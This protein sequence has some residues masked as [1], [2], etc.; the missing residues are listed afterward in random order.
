[1][2]WLKLT[3]ATP[4]E[5]VVNTGHQNNYIRMGINVWEKTQLIAQLT[6]KGSIK[7]RL[8]QSENSG[9]AQEPEDEQRT[10][11]V[12]NNVKDRINDYITSLYHVKEN[13]QSKNATV[14]V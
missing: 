14:K 3:G 4:I 9:W 13:D 5:T 1:M 8:P 7:A 2:T 10:T 12:H 11:C 6:I